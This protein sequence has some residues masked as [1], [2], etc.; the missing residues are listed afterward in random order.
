VCKEPAIADTELTSSEREREQFIII[1][2]QQIFQA[3]IKIA[4]VSPPPPSSFL[5]Q[6]Y[7]TNAHSMGEYIKTQEN[8][9][10][11]F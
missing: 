4:F 1:K 2:L 6:S 3:L 11:E 10:S 8:L 9:K 7:A 5:R